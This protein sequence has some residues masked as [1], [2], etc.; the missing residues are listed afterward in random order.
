MLFMTRGADTIN[1][2]S[3]RADWVTGTDRRAMRLAFNLYTGNVPEDHDRAVVRRS[4][5]RDPYTE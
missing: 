1:P 3:L 5:R 4:E 2:E